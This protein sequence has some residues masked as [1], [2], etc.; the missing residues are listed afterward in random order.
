[1]KKDKW[2]WLDMDGS[3][4]DFYGVDGW[5]E[6]LRS[7]NERPYREAKP[8]YNTL[9]LLATLVDL[10]EKGYNI[11]IISWL[12]KVPTEEFNKRV[13]KAKMNWLENYGF[14]IILDKILIT[15]YGIKKADTCRKYGYGILIDDE[16]KNR[17]DW[18]LGIT[19]DATNN[20]IEILK[21]L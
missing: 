17:D 13:I 21:R 4:C 6:D 5:L 14:D 1:M 7:Y 16:K 8:L 15:A 9:D 12:S 3:I 20:I 19:V 18:D 11:G 2:I 10:K